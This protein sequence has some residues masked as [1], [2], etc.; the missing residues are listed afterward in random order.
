LLRRS[1]WLTVEGRGQIGAAGV[2]H[3]RSGRAAVAVR[4]DVAGGGPMQACRPRWPAAASRDSDCAWGRFCLW[5]QALVRL[6][7]GPWILWLVLRRHC[8]SPIRDDATT[9]AVAPRQGRARSDLGE[10]SRLRRRSMTVASCD[11]SRVP[12][13]LEAWVQGL[14]KRTTVRRRPL[15]RWAEQRCCSTAGRA[16]SGC[17]TA[18]ASGTPR[19]S[20]GLTLAMR[21]VVLARSSSLNRWFRTD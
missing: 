15:L 6:A 21:T 10:L 14:S 16:R 8:D 19:G 5:A 13:L 9:K 11:V 7:A 4:V 20:S 3:R 2:L 12:R 17:P 18:T 1:S